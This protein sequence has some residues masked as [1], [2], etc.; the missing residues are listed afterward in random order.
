M[1]SPVSLSASHRTEVVVVQR[2]VHVGL[3]RANPAP[4]AHAFEAAL[5]SLAAALGPAGAVRP[6]EPWSRS[7]HRPHFHSA[8]VVV[9]PAG[10]HRLRSR[11]WMP[12]SFRPSPGYGTATSMPSLS[13]HRRSPLGEVEPGGVQVLV[14]AGPC[15]TRRSSPRH[16]APGPPAPVVALASSTMHSSYPVSGFHRIE[17]PGRPGAPAGWPPPGPGS[18]H[19]CPSAST[20]TSQSVIGTPFADPPTVV[21]LH[22]LVLEVRLHGPRSAP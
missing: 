17:C 2:L 4:Q 3:G 6:P 21:G 11:S 7:G 19:R 14:S 1:G 18:S 13:K 9:D 16:V 12:P 5:A 20:T 22:P 10:G 15:R 8:A